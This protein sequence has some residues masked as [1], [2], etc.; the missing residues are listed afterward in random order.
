MSSSTVAHLQIATSTTSHASST[1]EPLFDHPSRDRSAS[2]RSPPIAIAQRRLSVAPEL[3]LIT[4][5]HL[6]SHSSDII[7]S[8]YPRH[9]ER[10]A[11]ISRVIGIRGNPPSFSPAEA[12]KH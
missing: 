3:V 8:Q 9:P 4:K 12:P 6:G 10:R 11:D 1:A 2:R 5:L 7:I